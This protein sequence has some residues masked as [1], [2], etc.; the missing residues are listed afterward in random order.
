M[1]ISADVLNVVADLAKFAPRELQE[2]ALNYVLRV[3]YGAGNAIRR[4]KHA[5]F[6]LHKHAL[7]RHTFQH[8]RICLP[9][10]RAGHAS[11]NSRWQYC[12]HVPFSS[13]GPA[14]RP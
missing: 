6:M 8:T 2:D 10:P 7:E 1:Q 12:L 14:G 11:V 3:A 9:R 4:P 5:F 13:A